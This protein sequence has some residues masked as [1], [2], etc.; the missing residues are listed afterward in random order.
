MEI[1]KENALEKIKNKQSLS[2]IGFSV[3]NLRILLA[4]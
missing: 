1:L 4:S 3:G 2:Q